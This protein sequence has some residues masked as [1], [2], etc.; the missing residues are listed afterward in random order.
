MV[1]YDAINIEQ[2]FEQGDPIS[3]YLYILAGQ[4][5]SS[6]MLDDRRGLL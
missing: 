1:S 3:P 4:V 6:L 2:G 5:Q